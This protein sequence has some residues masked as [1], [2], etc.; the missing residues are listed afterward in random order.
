M[1][2]LTLL[3]IKENSKILLGKKKRRFGAGRWNGFGGKLLP[4]ESILGSLKRELMEEA[5]IEVKEIKKIG[6]VIF[7]SGND[8]D[9][10]WKNFGV[11]PNILVH[12][13]I[14][15][16][17][18]GDPKETEE[19][20]PKWFHINEIPFDE[21][22]PD[23]VYWFPFVLEEIPFKGY[24]KFAGDSTTMLEHDFK[25]VPEYAY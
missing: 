3:I 2:E 14:G 21:M 5:E 4:G 10:D 15:K 20:I 17:V 6:E 23:D 16:G 25:K 12:V 13:F 22:W 18:I 11:E 9:S 24:C 1:Q 19:M 8:N 7:Y